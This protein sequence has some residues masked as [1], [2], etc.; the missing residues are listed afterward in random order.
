MDEQLAI[1]AV[2]ALAL[3]V[4][5]TGLVRHYALRANMLDLPN[6]R[7]S[8]TVPT[9][10]GGG[11]SIV[12]V[13][14][15][16]VVF[17]Y[18]QSLLNSGEALYL[19]A[20][21]MAI[22]VIGFADDY[23]DVARS[24]RFLVQLIVAIGAVVALGGMPET[25]FGSTVTDLGTVGDVLLVVFMVWFINLFNFMD[26]I[27]GLAGVELICISAGAVFLIGTGSGLPL[28]MLLTALSAATLGFLYWNWPPARIFM[29]DVGSAFAGFALVAIAIMASRSGYT[30]IWSWLI[31][32]GVFF[33]DATITLIIR[34][35]RGDRW[36]SAHRSHAYQIAARRFG[37]HKPVTLIVLAINIAWLFPLALYV[38]AN[39]EAGWWVTFIAWAPLAAM[40]IVLGAGRP[41]RTETASGQ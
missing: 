40:S 12:L 16:A 7:S 9:P 28:S 20:G 35:L 26:G 41:D 2:L 32:S 39:P 6:E 33:V 29:G 36:H 17:A 30:S 19:L 4:A 11:L 21:S 27:D 31:L 15:A 5:I 8:H 34:I 3:G 13:F 22:A 23:R 18:E 37:S 24:W 38:D 1:I 10:R 14:I 25:N